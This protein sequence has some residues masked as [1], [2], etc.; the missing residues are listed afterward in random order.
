MVSLIILIGIAARKK[1]P[2]I[3]VPEKL[4]S[5]YSQGAADYRAG[6]NNTREKLGK[7]NIPVPVLCGDHDISFPV[8]NW[9]VLSGKKAV[10]VFQSQVSGALTHH[11]NI[12][13]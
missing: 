2:D 1:D 11:C 10:R 4:W 3:P 7:L 8:E 9:Y 6:N 5:R 13:P 12:A